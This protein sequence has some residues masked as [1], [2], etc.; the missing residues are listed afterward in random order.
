MEVLTDNDV[1]TP[2]SLAKWLDYLYV[3][4]GIC[5]AASAQRIRCV[6]LE[7]WKPGQIG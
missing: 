5:F 7:T 2:E 3:E 4:R 6:M 1:A